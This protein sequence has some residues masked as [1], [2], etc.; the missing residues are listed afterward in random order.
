MG[1]ERRFLSEGSE[2]SEESDLR[3]R[4]R[5]GGAALKHRTSEK[6]ADALGGCAEG[7]AK[8]PHTSK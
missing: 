4:V 8:G 6:R 2:L 3:R 1:L 7:G 5:G